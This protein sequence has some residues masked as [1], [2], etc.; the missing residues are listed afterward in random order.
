MKL[1]KLYLKNFRGYLETEIEFN[2]DLNVIIGRNDVGKSTILDA[3]DYFFNE[4]KIEHS[5]CHIDAEDRNITIGV[6]FKVSDNDFV[7]LDATNP[8]TLKDEFLLNEDGYFE[9]RKVINAS[10]KTITATNVS[11]EIIAHHPEILSQPLI[12]NNISKLKSLLDD[13]STEIPEYSEINK[14]KKA[15]IRKALFNLL[16]NETTVF[17][18]ISIPLKSLQDDN[19]N[20][21]AK[22]KGNLPIFN[23]FQSDR[24]NTDGDKEVQDPMKA[25]T[26]EALSSLQSDLD[27]IRDEVVKKVEEIGGSTIEKLKEFNYE[28]ASQL[29]TLPELKGWDS[30]FKFSLDTDEDIPLNK[31]GSGVRRLILLSYFRAQSEKKSTEHNNS[32][33]IYAIEEPETSQHP[34]FQKNDY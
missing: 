30:V 8:T 34:D 24:T 20:S 29:K 10:N 33:I 28:I 5:D 12:T 26:K 9:I 23:L 27:R 32:N 18:K 2:E 19:M 11:I 13:Y 3:L 17:N 14:T 7:F 15:D 16:V 4:S 31:R 6:A 25:I 22:V 21:W 1:V